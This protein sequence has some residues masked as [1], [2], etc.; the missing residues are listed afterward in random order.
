VA[1]AFGGQ[2]RGVFNPYEE[3][4]FSA[5][6]ALAADDVW[7]VGTI[8]RQ[9]DTGAAPTQTFTEHWDG[10]AWHVVNAPDVHVGQLQHGADDS[11]YAVT[12][13]RADDV[14]AVGAAS[15]A[16]TLTLHWDGTSW[17]VIP[18]AHGGSD[19]YLGDVAAIS[20]GN[21]WAVGNAIEHWDGRRWTETAT[22]G[23][24]TFKPLAAIAAVSADDIWMVGEDDFLH[25]RC[26][27]PVGVRDGLRGREG[28]TGLERGS[29][30]TTAEG[31]GR[32]SRGT[33]ERRYACGGTAASSWCGPEGERP[34][35][36]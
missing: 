24:K 31:S 23:G 17:S 25:Y 6:H 18:S 5:V 13:V 12:A 30:A 1:S 10:T 8:T 19:S 21:V 9:D 33:A 15:P 16:G 2:S 20:A 32:D 3:A 4:S 14:W 22:I 35:D 27:Q 36:F 7:A 11:L 26:R 28:F 34:R 29:V